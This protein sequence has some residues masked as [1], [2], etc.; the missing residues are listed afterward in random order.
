[1]CHLFW[2]FCWQHNVVTPSMY[3]F[4]VKV[5]KQWRGEQSGAQHHHIW[6]YFMWRERYKAAA[7][8]LFCANILSGA[9][10]VKLI[11][12]III[13]VE[14]HKGIHW[15]LQRKYN[16]PQQQHESTLDCFNLRYFSIWNT[17]TAVSV[18]KTYSNNC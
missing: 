8:C 6:R 10:Y 1:M 4:F 13:G 5:V 9:S 18:E 2:I 15:A 3:L 16:K 17:Q 14:P 12:N 11:K 7:W